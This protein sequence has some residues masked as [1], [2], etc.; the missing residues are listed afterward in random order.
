MRLWRAAL[1]ALTLLALGAAGAR[2]APAYGGGEL[3]WDRYG[4]A[5]V[6]AKTTEGLFYAYGFA[7]AKS[8]GGAVVKLCATS[9]VAAS[10][11]RRP[12]APLSWPTTAGWRPMRFRRAPPRG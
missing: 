3:L 12:M 10:E 2:A 8:H 9:C 11:R 4:V 7:Q 5:H 6:Y 1:A